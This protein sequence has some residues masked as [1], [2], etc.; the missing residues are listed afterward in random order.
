MWQFCIYIIIYILSAQYV[1]LVNNTDAYNAWKSPP[2]AIFI[3][4]H[5]FDVEN[6]DDVV[7]NKSKPSVK[8]R[9]P[10]VYRYTV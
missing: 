2:E 7:R 9:G 4:F 8:E 5:F 1:K 3:D 6:P 10:Y